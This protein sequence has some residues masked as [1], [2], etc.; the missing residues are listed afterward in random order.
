MAGIVMD[1]LRNPTK[2]RHSD[3]FL[4]EFTRQFWTRALAL[5]TPN[6]PCIQHFIDGFEEYTT[7]VAFEAEDRTNKS[8][9]TV[10]EYLLLR[11]G[12]SS[13]KSIFA[14]IEFGLD[15]P[16]YVLSHPIV[17]NLTTTAA[18]LCA[19][20]N[21][22]HSYSLE[23]ARGLDGHNIITSIMSEHNLDLQSALD[24]LGS[25][26]DGLVA[27]FLSDMKRLPSWNETID[28]NLKLYI[29][30][31]GHWVRGNES[32]C[33]ESKRYY[34]ELGSHVRKTQLIQLRNP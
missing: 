9:R 18:D 32:W 26:M 25:L 34:G 20:T 13:S 5:S 19:I 29:D 15:L 6:A 24:W 12:T 17:S 31:L 2:A 8:V 28:A 7:A 4:G 22:L 21:D 30:S 23:H 27:R 3:H 11:R 33:Y 1:V 10:W 14:L 16:D